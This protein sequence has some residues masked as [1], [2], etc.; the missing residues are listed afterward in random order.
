MT[1]AIGF[2][3]L[4]SLGFVALVGAYDVTGPPAW[5]GLAI[6]LASPLLFRALSRFESARP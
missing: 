2:L 1:R 5:R 6:L 3:V 4:L